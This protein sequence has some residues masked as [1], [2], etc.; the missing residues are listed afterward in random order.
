M[1]EKLI[2][3]LSAVETAVSN[4]SFTKAENLL[5]ET[6]NELRGML[7]RLKAAKR[8]TA[9]ILKTSEEIEAEKEARKSGKD[10]H[11]E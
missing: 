4:G 10:S 11:S 7:R 9:N 5:E 2:E 1:M 8:N 3:N 6:V